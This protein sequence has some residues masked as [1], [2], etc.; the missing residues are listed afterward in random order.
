MP[1]FT[2]RI[3]IKTGLIISSSSSVSRP[4][5]HIFRPGILPNSVSTWNPSYQSSLMEP[6]Q[7]YFRYTGC[8]IWSRFKFFKMDQYQQKAF[9]WR[10]IGSFPFSSHLSRYPALLGKQQSTGTTESITLPTQAWK[11]RSE[12][13]RGE[14]WEKVQLHDE[15]SGSKQRNGQ[16]GERHRAQGLKGELRGCRSLVGRD[17]KKKKH[18]KWK[19]SRFLYIP[20]MALLCYL[21]QIGTSLSYSEQP[22]IYK[23]FIG[24][25]S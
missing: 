9:T 7:L 24:S 25:L 3:L 10:T 15:A 23:V 14:T 13:Q 21:E 8:E 12:K 20:H 1:Q 6:T 11:T 19:T 5:Q 4:H 2:V 18:Q 22:W 17:E 16:E